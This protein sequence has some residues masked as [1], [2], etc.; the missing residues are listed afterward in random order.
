MAIAEARKKNSRNL[1]PVLPS[2]EDD[3]V[4][5]T[6][7]KVK[8]QQQLAFHM[9]NTTTTNHNNIHLNDN[10]TITTIKIN[11]QCRWTHLIKHQIDTSMQWRL[12]GVPQQ[13]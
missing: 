1:R 13:A 7:M 9:E 5:A 4:A 6:A 12:Q 8:L 11:N 10:S 3:V 2:H